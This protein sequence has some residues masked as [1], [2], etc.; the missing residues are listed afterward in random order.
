P[1]PRLPIP[2]GPPGVSSGAGTGGTGATSQPSSVQDLND[3]PFL[4]EEVDLG[5]RG[6]PAQPGGGPGAVGQTVERALREVLG[7]R[8]RASDPKGFQAALLQAFT[9]EEVAGHTEDHWNPGSHA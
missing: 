2:T 5:G 3:F 6:A 4:T 7:W 9:A 8:P 1:A